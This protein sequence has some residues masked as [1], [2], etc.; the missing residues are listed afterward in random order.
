[1][2]MDKGAVPGRR[3][4]WLLFLGAALLPLASLLI[5]GTGIFNLPIWLIPFVFFGPLFVLMVA[6]YWRSPKLGTYATLVVTGFL[7]G[8]LVTGIGGFILLMF[9]LRGLG[10]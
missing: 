5:A 7:S 1:M 10:D 6:S 4:K 9:L 3:E 2:R 8:Y